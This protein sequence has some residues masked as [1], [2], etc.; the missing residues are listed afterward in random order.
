MGN[1]QTMKYQIQKDKK[2]LEIASKKSSELDKSTTD[3]KGTVNNLKKAPIVKN[4]YTIS[5][6]D[7]NKILEYIDKVDKT[8]TDFKRTEKLSV[9]INNVDTELEENREKIKILTENNE[10]LSPKVDTLSKNIE[11]KNKE[12]KELKKDYKH[13]EE[14]VDYFKD[15]F[16]RLIIFIRHK[17]FE[18]DK[19]RENYWE[20]SNDLYE[21]GIFS[22]KTI[23]DLKEEYNWGKEHDKYKDH[24]GF[25]LEI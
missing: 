11:N 10:A 16:N 7:K 3:I 9:T 23:K 15:L 21:R 8:N 18:K 6:N 20:F 25:D 12:I 2:A 24:D 17:M 4:T 14:L 22:D 1:Y 13:L 5:E 19:E